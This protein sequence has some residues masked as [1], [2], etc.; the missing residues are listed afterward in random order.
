MQIK[1]GD[2]VELEYTGMLKN[3]QMIFDTTNADTAKKV[4]IFNEQKEY[5]PIIVCVGHK[6]LLKGLDTAVETAEI[7]KE[8][9]VEISP[10]DGF[11]KKRADLFQLIATP[12][13]RKHGI[14]PVPGL[15]VNVDNAVGVIKTVTGGRTLVDF[16]H[17]CASKDIVYTFTVKRMVTDTKEKVEALLQQLFGK[18]LI[19]HVTVKE[20]KAEV[21][22]RIEIPKELQEKCTE[23]IQ[24]TVPEVTVI[25]YS[26]KKDEKIIENV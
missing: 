5:G 13:F 12:K 15:Q 10:E 24:E 6:Q 3:E 4:G 17:P 21:A 8:K 22:L 25:T 9:K 16:N 18:A 2:F 19:A 20:G 26:V 11:G 14:N 23:K 7:G 1:K